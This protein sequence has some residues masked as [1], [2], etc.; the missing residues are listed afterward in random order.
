MFIDIQQIQQRKK[1]KF[2][3]TLIL[4]FGGTLFKILIDFFVY[5]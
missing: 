2:L 1:K 4:S 3:P 5:I